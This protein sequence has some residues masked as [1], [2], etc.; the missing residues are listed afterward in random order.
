M[1]Q[2]AAGEQGRR[3]ERGFGWQWTQLGQWGRGGAQGGTSEG[4][5]DEGESGREAERLR[6]SATAASPAGA[7]MYC[8]AEA[9][10]R[11]VAYASLPIKRLHHRVAMQ[12]VRRWIEYMWDLALLKRL[13]PGA[14]RWQA[15]CVRRRSIELAFTVTFERLRPTGGR[16]GVERMRPA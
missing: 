6:G 10:F 16:G 15:N 1:L 11:T 5:D 14:M 4:A 12:D 9:I 13:T 7:T 2:V 3:G 8:T